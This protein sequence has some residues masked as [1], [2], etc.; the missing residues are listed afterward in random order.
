MAARLFRERGY[1][2]TSMQEIADEMGI[3]K[4]SLYHYVRT[5]E[6]LLWM[7]MEPRLRALT[8][9]VAAILNDTSVPLRDRIAQAIEAHALSFEQDAPH[10]F[11]ITRESG[12]TLS[13]ERRAELRKLRDGYQRV[14]KKAIAS[15]IESGELKSEL[16]ANVAVEAI[17]GMVNWMHRWFTP[18]RRTNATDIARQFSII[19]VDGMA[20]DAKPRKKAKP[21]R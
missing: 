17:F 8:E 1:D 4:G 10:M 5:K 18:S 11:V 20:G 14:W 9:S 15:G 12:D 19:A 6:D 21:K 13:D 3:L 16:D 2:A 7:I